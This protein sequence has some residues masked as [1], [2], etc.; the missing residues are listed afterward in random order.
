MGVGWYVNQDTLM[1]RMWYVESGYGVHEDDV[2]YW[3]SLLHYISTFLSV[4]MLLL[5]VQQQHSYTQ[6]RAN[7]V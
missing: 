3:S 5:T 2:V 4:T 7:M 1:V 6:E